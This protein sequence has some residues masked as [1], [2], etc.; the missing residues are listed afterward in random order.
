[1]PSCLAVVR[2][3]DRGP[4]GGGRSSPSV[5]YAR[6]EPRQMPATYT[7]PAIKPPANPYGVLRGAFVLA[8][9]PIRW[10]AQSLYEGEPRIFRR[11]RRLYVMVS[12]PADAETILLGKAECFRRSYIADITLKPVLGLGLLTSDGE[13]WRGQRRITAPAFRP[14]ALAGLAPAMAAAAAAGVERLSG[15]RERE[16]TAAMTGITFDVIVRTVFGAGMPQ[17]DADAMSRDLSIYLASVGNPDVLDLFDAPAFVPHPWKWR[18]YRAAERIRAMAAAALAERRRQGA[19][20]GDLAALLIGARDPETGDP[21]AEERIVDNLITFLVAG[22]E[23]TSLA[24]TWTL[25]LLAHL[26]DLQDRL[27]AESTAILGDGLPDAEA[28]DRLDLHRRVLMEAMRLFPPAPMIPRSV[29]APVTVA[30]ADLVPDDHV[31]VT[32]YPMHRRPDLWPEPGRF[33]PDRFL[34][35]RTAGRHR[36]AWLPFGGGPRICIG[37]GFAML[38]ATIILSAVVRRL[39][40]APASPFPLPVQRVTLR[41]QTPVVLSLSPR[42][43]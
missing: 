34:P 42:T 35:E 18:G 38:E 9:N 10:F 29:V 5:P 20:G 22:H 6:P 32:T 43:R 24:L 21:M 8:R 17:L 26:P 19:A 28:A 40:L 25:A 16:I 14:A 30:G 15:N 41:P 4:P 7:P 11:G 39:R 3:E 33:D 27:A 13:S 2:M 36:F 1:M 12:D 31:A 23:T 37:M